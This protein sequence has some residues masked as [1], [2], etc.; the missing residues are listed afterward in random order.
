MVSTAADYAKFGQMLLNGGALDGVRLLSPR[1][2]AFMTSDQLPPDIAYSPAA[3]QIMEPAGIA[4]TPRDGQGFG[5]GFAVRTQTGRNFREGSPGDFYWLGYWGTDFWVDPKERLVVVYMMQAP[6]P[7]LTHY[8]SV[9][10]NLVYQAL[11]N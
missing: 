8:M 7:A 2:V 6:P 5:L 4:P 1:T 9:I 11:V 3:L 10:R